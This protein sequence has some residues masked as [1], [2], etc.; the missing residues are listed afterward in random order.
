VLV[1]RKESNIVQRRLV[2]QRRGELLGLQG[3][4]E[5]RLAQAQ[6]RQHRRQQEDRRVL[7]LLRQGLQP[8]HPRVPPLEPAQVLEL[9]RPPAG[10]MPVPE[11]P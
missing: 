6:A 3:A 7:H 9:L 8:V 10:L 4:L 1:R 11:V 5:L 2:R